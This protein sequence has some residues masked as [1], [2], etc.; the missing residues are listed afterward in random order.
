[1]TDITKEINVF[2]KFFSEKPEGMSKA[3]WIKQKRRMK[4]DRIEQ[5]KQLKLD[6]R[7]EFKLTPI[8]LYEDQVDK[9]G[10]E[11]EAE[12]IRQGI[13]CDTCKLIT[14]VYSYMMKLFKDF[15]EGRSI[16]LY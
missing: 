12:G 1:M 10:C 3:E 11:C 9:I 15:A 4:K 16:A 8:H 2:N 6:R 5:E 13:F 14:K 7:L